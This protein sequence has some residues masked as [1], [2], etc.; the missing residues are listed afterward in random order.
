MPLSHFKNVIGSIGIATTAA[1][2][3]SYVGAQP[4]D[5]FYSANFDNQSKTPEEMKFD[6]YQL[7]RNEQAVVLM[8][9]NIMNKFASNI[10]DNISDLDPDFSKTVD[11]NFWDLI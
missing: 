3:Y 4:V 1:L 6:Y 10:L 7:V 11:E 5:S 2:C 8:Q 9:I